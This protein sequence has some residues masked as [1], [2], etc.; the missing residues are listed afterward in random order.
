MGF[1]DVLIR[2]AEKRLN[3]R[4]NK[5]LQAVKRS[6]AHMQT[7]IKNF[8]DISNLE[9][10]MMP[11]LLKETDLRPLVINLQERAEKLAHEKILDL[12]I[13]V[14]DEACK[15][16]SDHQLIVQVLEILINNAVKYTEQG[17]ITI[18]LDSMEN[19][20]LGNAFCVSVIDTGIGLSSTQQKE[21]FSQLG[22][23]LSDQL[24]MIDGTGLGLYLAAQIMRLLKGAIQCESDG[25]T[26]STFRVFFRK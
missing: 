26:G 5:C 23:Y 13:C 6:A 7:L 20:V 22:G 9:R 25:S 18:V 14:P 3:E 24:Q 2:D 4:D 17:K 21:I 15:I 19:S 12:E 11:V 1:T 8:R 10:E 16:L